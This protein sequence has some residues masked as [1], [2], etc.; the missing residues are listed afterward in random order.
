VKRG[1]AARI[2]PHPL[3]SEMV[4]FDGHQQRSMMLPKR[5]RA[6]CEIVGGGRQQTH[7]SRGKIDLD[8]VVAE[9]V[10]S[11]QSIQPAIAGAAENVQV[12]AQQ[13]CRKRHGV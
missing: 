8:H 13:V 7:C 3:V 11:Q 12:H 10:G 1:G 9:K 5:K 2:Q 6:A 4:D